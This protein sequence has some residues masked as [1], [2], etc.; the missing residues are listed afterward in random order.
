MATNYRGPGNVIMITGP[1]GGLSSNDPYAAGRIAL[2]ADVDIAEGTEGAACRVGKFTL[3]VKG[4]DGAGNSAVVFG[5]QLYY[6]SGDTPKISKK[7]TGVPFGK[8]LA[9]VTPGSTASIDVQLEG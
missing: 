5:D 9:A 6:V 4:I 3:S 7:A 8:A 1:S 2:V